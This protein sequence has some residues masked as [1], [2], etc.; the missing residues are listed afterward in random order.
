MILA[1][2]VAAL[3]IVVDSPAQHVRPEPARTI[4]AWIEAPGAETPVAL[5]R[6]E[7]E[8]A[9]VGGLARTTLLL[10][11]RNPNARILEGTLQFPLQPGQQVT[12]F[13]LDIDGAMRD[14]VPVPKQQGRQVFESIERRNVDPA[15]LEQTAGN[16]FRLRVYPL[17]ARGTRQVR[18]VLDEP[19]RRDG[20][21]WRLALP[22]GLLSAASAVSLRVHGATQAPILDGAF[23]APQWQRDGDGQRTALQRGDAGSA[24]G[25]SVHFPASAS[26]RAHVGQHGDVHYVLAELPVAATSKPR[27]IPRHV[28]LLWDASASGRKR[29]HAGEFALLDR[30]FKAMGDGRV[31]LRLL[32]DRGMDG[33]SFQVRGGDW[34]E[35]RKALST[36]VYDGATDLADWTPAQD[37]GEYL[38]V[39]DGLRNYGMQS[40]PSLAAG[41]RLY[42][43]ASTTA[44]ASRL[45]ALAEAR[46]GRMVAWQGRAGLDAAAQALL[47]DGSHVVALEG[48][49]VDQLV[50]QSRWVDEG[51]LRVAG[52][53]R[54]PAGTI[55]V[56]IQDASGGRRIKLPVTSTGIA[57]PQVPQAW[58]TWSVAQLSAEPERNRAAIARLGSEFSLVTAGT[59]LL[60]LDDPADYVR[61]DIPAPPE[62]QA[63]VASLR[64]TQTQSREASRTQRLDALSM[65]FAGRIAW[66]ERE[67]PKGARPIVEARKAAAGAGALYSVAAPASSANER[68]AA[69]SV[70][71]PPA[72]V[73]EAPAADAATLD[74]VAVVGSGS[75]R[76]R[77][78]DGASG[79]STGARA[80][81]IRLQSW[82]PDSPYARRLRA[83]PTD[84]LYALYL[85][86]RDS[87]AASTAFYLDVAG[88]L[89]QRDR[90]DEALRVLS[91]L[92]ELELENRH[93]LRVLGY[94][95]MQAKAY[96]LAVQVFRQVS[97]MADEEPQSHRDLALA[98]AADGARQEAIRHLYDVA[99]RQWDGRFAEIELVA[100]N[101][102]NQIVAT[103][104]AQLDTG[105]IDPRLLKNMPLDLRVALSWDS[106]NSDMD[107][108]VT[109]PNGEKCYYSNTL[110]YQGGLISDDFTGG[111]GPE[112][113]V[114]RD[115]KPGK[116]RIEAHYFGD[117]QQVVTGATTLSLRLSTAWG[118]RK[119]RDQTVTLR[120]SGKNESVL[121]GE[122]EV[123]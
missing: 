2:G 59:S 90:R 99:T 7:V 5:E 10:T 76:E 39:S 35:L 44:D 95:L 88:M 115:A 92:A 71:P 97:E 55:I 23:N 16:H 1:A 91:N 48:E 112:E 113:F 17:P 47:S 4:P 36:T 8:V 82:E 78:E 72:P 19:M 64:A 66:W 79:Q 103:S 53:L 121:V 56:T 119:Q 50:A 30:Y 96:P 51:I 94:R 65:D 33:G 60:V 13:A 81:T 18:L 114:L 40:V 122:F 70:A 22:A 26:V 83:A 118:T 93:V 116:Y 27:V 111:Y 102:L 43:L 34:S 9:T 25:L 87:R 12:A 75:A 100:L 67:F 63:Q 58:A 61:Y 32:R 74:T 24:A 98:L 85:D 38:L 104:P 52:R 120:L 20:E 41:Q 3:G 54:E 86:E 6:A 73:A 80:A 105:F 110:T 31:Q 77:D 37:I 84:Q 21:H 117:R 69:A 123:E 108:W 101:E 89:L 45:A 15:L 28:G 106:D 29:D 109:D 57:Y 49:G 11:L 107:L 46:G 42:A 68:A 14:A 62:L